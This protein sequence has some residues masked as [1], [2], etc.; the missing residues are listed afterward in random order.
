MQ[1]EQCLDTTRW[2]SRAGAVQR[3]VGPQVPV[4]ELVRFPRRLWPH[5]CIEGQHAVEQTQDA[6]INE[7][8]HWRCQA[9]RAAEIFT[10]AREHW[11]SA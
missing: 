2:A 3:D 6:G 5:A 10:G 4:R 8:S 9:I 11:T 1:A 7:A